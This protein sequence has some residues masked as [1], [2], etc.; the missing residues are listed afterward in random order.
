MWTTSHSTTDTLGHTVQNTWLI[1]ANWKLRRHADFLVQ[2]FCVWKLSAYQLRLFKVIHSWAV[3]IMG[4]TSCMSNSCH[5]HFR[6]SV[7]V[8]HYSMLLLLLQAVVYHGLCG[9]DRWGRHGDF[10]WRHLWPE[11]FTKH[12]WNLLD[13][14]NKTQQESWKDSKNSTTS[15]LKIMITT[16]IATVV[17]I[18]I[19]QS[20]PIQSNPIHQSINQSIVTMFWWC[21]HIFPLIAPFIRNFRASRV[22]VPKGTA[23]PPPL[24]SFWHL[25]LGNPK[26]GPHHG[27]CYGMQYS[28]CMLYYI[29]IHNGLIPGIVYYTLYN[30]K[31]LHIY[32]YN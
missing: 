29:M 6:C 28:K 21:S 24:E 30:L 19:N 16:T 14:V 31:V 15:R 2:L 4:V 5:C 22:W 27:Y 26:P 3:V 13:K 9:A 18:I 11:N 20:N 17:I 25:K 10:R 23:D 7:P 8:M 32:I 12:P 1:V